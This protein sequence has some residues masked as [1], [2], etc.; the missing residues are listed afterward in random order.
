MAPS[1]P[2]RTTTCNVSYKQPD[3]SDSPGASDTEEQEA[4]RETT[5]RPRPR[6]KKPNNRDDEYETPEDEVSQQGDQPLKE[7]KEKT[8]VEKGSSEQSKK[9]MN[10]QPENPPSDNPLTSPDDP[11]LRPRFGDNSH[12]YFDPKI[13]SEA[14]YL[15]D[16]DHA[17]GPCVR[18]KR[19]CF[20]DPNNVDGRCNT[21]C[22]QSGRYT[23]RPQN[24]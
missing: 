7:R 11:Q 4:P 16:L 18:Y 24:D 3:D 5:S 8:V 6:P 19:R 9:A 22:R 1:R 12:Q 15:I 23:C 20:W 2:K 10:K 21:C 14:P 13:P 17:C